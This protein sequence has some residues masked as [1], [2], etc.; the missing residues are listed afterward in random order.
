M[1]QLLVLIE[2]VVRLSSPLGVCV[3]SVCLSEIALQQV[4]MFFRSDLKWEV[5][6]PLRD[7][8]KVKMLL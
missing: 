6:E 8:G 4:S 2:A 5:L 1:T 3:C 7:M